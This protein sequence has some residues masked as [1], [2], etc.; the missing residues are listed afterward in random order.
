MNPQTA[1]IADVAGDVKSRVWRK[2]RLSTANFAAWLAAGVLSLNLFIAVFV[3]LTMHQGR[4]QYEERAATSTQNLAIALENELAGIVKTSDIAL[5]AV[6]DEYRRQSSGHVDGK[7]LNAFIQRLGARL[8]Y[9]NAIRVADAQ[10]R[11]LY[12]SD[13]PSGA[14]I[15]ISDRE[16]FVHLRE[17]RATGLVISRPQRSRIN[18]KWVVVL[19]RRFDAADASFAG[20]V[21][22]AIA[23][24]D[25]TKTLSKI[26]VGVNGTI[27]LRGEDLGI[28]ARY[29][30][31]DGFGASIGNKEV[32]RDLREL[33]L[34]HKEAG[35]F[36]TVTPLDKVERMLSYRRAAN[37][38]LYIAVGRATDEY[39]GQWRIATT[40]AFVTV[41]A[42]FIATLFLSWLVFRYWKQLELA[43]EALEHQA[44]TDFLTGLANR[45]FF[46]ESAENELARSARYGK[47][48]S[49]LMLDIDHFKRINDTYGHM[50]GDVVLQ[51]L[52]DLCRS[53]LREV[54]IMGRWGGEEFSILLPETDGK[55]AEE[56]AERIRRLVAD[57]GV[58]LKQGLP[59]KLTISIGVATHTDKDDNI[60]MLI[61]R[62]DQALYGA[63]NA[64]RNRVCTET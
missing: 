53:T 20:M 13:T 3:G 63:K 47:A 58:A 48:V 29:P 56:A 49:I 46:L 43:T 42:F 41:A 14:N 12:G 62:A 59:L 4:L 10:G 11:V 8:P 39:L 38:P 61:D 15:N 55:S 22:A 45:R 5:L 25:L 54:D 28:I 16:H 33:V 21:F 35:T 1:A 64:G 18:D 32:S 40:R 26:D 7:T 60:D 2:A 27:T 31:P 9:L 57:T 30:E 23:V 51:K 52:A 44:H 17:N 6:I 34:A 36:H 19:A 50:T 37:Y 24:E